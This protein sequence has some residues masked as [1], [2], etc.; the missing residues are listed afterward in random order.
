ML[1]VVPIPNLDRPFTLRLLYDGLDTNTM[2]FAYPVPPL[3]IVN[4]REPPELIDALTE[5]AIP[6]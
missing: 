2:G 5:A 1:V 6:V 4:A 3:R